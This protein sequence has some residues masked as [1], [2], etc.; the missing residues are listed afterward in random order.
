MQVGVCLAE[1]DAWSVAHRKPINLNASTRDENGYLIIAVP[2][3][4]FLG[5]RVFLWMI[6]VREG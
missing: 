3:R 6:Y 1:S 4:N 5:A 2:G